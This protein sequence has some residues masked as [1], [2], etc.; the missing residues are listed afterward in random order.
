M[1]G[2]KAFRNWF[3]LNCV[4][5]EH[6]G[7]LPALAVVAIKLRVSEARAAAAIAEMVTKKLFDKREDGT[8]VPHD[9]NEWQFKTDEADPTNAERQKNFRA[10]QRAEMAEL[11][12]LRDA[13]KSALRNGVRNGVTS[14]MAKRP[15]T[16]TD[17]TTTASVERKGLGGGEYAG[18]PE[19]QNSLSRFKQ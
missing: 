19:F 2:D 8:F 13:S 10:R 5:N 16:D 14:V 6:G 9:W 17:I 4:A 15:D 1:L 18:T 12:A 3:N 11:K 7:V